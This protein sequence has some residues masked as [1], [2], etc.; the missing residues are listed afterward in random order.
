MDAGEYFADTDKNKIIVGRKLG[1]KLGLKIR[2]KIVLTFQDAERNIASGAFRVIGFYKTYNSTLEQLNVYVRDGDL[3]SLLELSND[4]HEIA[5]LVH[6]PDS[7]DQILA[8]YRVDFP[9]G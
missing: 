9:R 2:S 4:G 6:A 5:A 3:A 8:E 7:L 1:K